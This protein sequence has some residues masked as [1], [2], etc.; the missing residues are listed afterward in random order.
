MQKHKVAKK[1]VKYKLKRKNIILI[2]F[3]YKSR[4][5]ILKTAILVILVLLSTAQAQYSDPPCCQSCPQHTRDQ[6]IF[7]A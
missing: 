6:Y 1:P 3:K 7:G 4:Q 5:M 2:I